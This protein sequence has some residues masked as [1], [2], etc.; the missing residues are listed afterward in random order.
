[1]VAFFDNSVVIISVILSKKLRT[2]KN[3]FVVNLN[4]ADL[5]LTALKL[6]WLVIAFLSVDGWSL[7][8]QL[9]V[10]CPFIVLDAVQQLLRSSLLT[11]WF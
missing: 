1:M 8:D 3:A 6:P 4:V 7:H 10:L 11:D 2:I 5:L 9:C